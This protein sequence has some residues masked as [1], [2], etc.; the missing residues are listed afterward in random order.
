MKYNW[1]VMREEEKIKLK[2][3]NID[4]IIEDYIIQHCL[5]WC[6]NLMMVC[7]F[8]LSVILSIMLGKP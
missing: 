1:K 3:R 4:S 6:N 5:G 2:G 8:F 7:I